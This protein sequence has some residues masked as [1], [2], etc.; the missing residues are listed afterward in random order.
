MWAELVRDY[1]D[2]IDLVEVDRDSR[3]GRRFAE[4]HGIYYQPGF[5]VFDASGEV[6]YAG[7]GPFDPMD[8]RRLVEGVAGAT[9]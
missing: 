8:V 2:S 9:R 4:R 3:D 1:G 5:V 7:L 6:T